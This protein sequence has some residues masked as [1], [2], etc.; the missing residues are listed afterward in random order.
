MSA[1]IRI[2][3]SGWHYPHWKKRFYPADVPPAGWLPYYARRLHCVEVN[4]TFYRLPDSR[5]VEGWRAHTPEDFTF[6]I[7]AS[8]TITHRKKLKQCGQ[9]VDEFLERLSPL[10]DK[11]DAILFQLPPR[12]HCN[13]GRLS[14]FLECL[15]PEWRYAFE[16]RDPSWH[17]ETVYALLRKANAA[18]CLYELGDSAT[19]LITTA[20]FVYIRLHG[21]AGPYAGSYAVPT[22]R[23]W[24]ERLLRWQKEGKDCWLFFDNDQNAYAVKNAMALQQLLRQ[25][26]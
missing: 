21:P 13:T 24:R 17:D 23:Y 26:T 6:T 16:F 12:W 5:T 7:K 19:P 11:I 22:L 18:L 10:K 15:P 3:T 14:T 8:Q 2:G 4:N 1:A 9:L 25:D 20:D